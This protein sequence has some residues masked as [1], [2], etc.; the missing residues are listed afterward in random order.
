MSCIIFQKIY[1]G[2]VESLAMPLADDQTQYVEEN[3]LQFHEEQNLVPEYF[4]HIFENS[5]LVQ[6]VNWQEAGQ[7]YFTLMT[8]IASGT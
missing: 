8:L 4:E 3:L 5:G 1:R 7:L 6:P 2:G